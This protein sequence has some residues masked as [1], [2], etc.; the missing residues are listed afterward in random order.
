MTALR[1]AVLA[2][3]Q[4]DLTRDRMER[5]ETFKGSAPQ[6]VREINRIG[7]LQRGPA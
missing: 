1:D 3:M 2:F 5:K 6:M 7:L 4:A